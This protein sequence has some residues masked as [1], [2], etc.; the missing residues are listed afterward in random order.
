MIPSPATLQ[1]LH[2]PSTLLITQIPRHTTQ[3]GI[4]TTQSFL[5]PLLPPQT[6][7]TGTTTP[8]AQAGAIASVY[9]S[10]RELFGA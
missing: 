2:T 1:Y 6:M 4:L 9:I 8:L 10:L 3:I 5:Q 7:A